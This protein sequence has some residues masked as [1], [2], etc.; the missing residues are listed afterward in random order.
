MRLPWP[1][2]SL[3]C[4]ALHC[5]ALLWTQAFGA[6]LPAYTY[7]LMALA[8]G[9]PTAGFVAFEMWKTLNENRQIR[10]ARQKLE[11]ISQV[12][13]FVKNK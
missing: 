9:V 2:P 12:I 5:P 13:E 4:L 1:T 3:R 7:V 6:D 10:R 11:D 8:L